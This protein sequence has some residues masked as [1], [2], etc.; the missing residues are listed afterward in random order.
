MCIP[1]FLGPHQINNKIQANVSDTF[2][3]RLHPATTPQGTVPDAGWS[4]LKPK[5][6]VPF[7]LSSHGLGMWAM[8]DYYG[9]AFMGWPTFV[10]SRGHLD[11]AGFPRATV[12]RPTSTSFSK[13]VSRISQLTPP[14]HTHTRARAHAHTYTV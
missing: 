12:R 2:N 1:D 5:Q 6:T 7:L 9:E 3:G 13:P 11:I 8:A 10:K 14:T 4:N